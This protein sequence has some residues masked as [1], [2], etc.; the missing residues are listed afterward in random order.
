MV[1]TEEI[2]QAVVN[3]AP[4]VTRPKLGFSIDSIVGKNRAVQEESRDDGDSDAP[5]SRTPSP[6]NRPPHDH[7]TH[8]LHHRGIDSPGSADSDPE[9]R[10]AQPIPRRPLPL[11]Q[12]HLDM[13]DPLRAPFSVGFPTPQFL[14]R[15]PDQPQPQ[16]LYP[17]LLAARHSRFFAQRFPGP[18]VPSFLLHPFR[19]PKRIRTAF[20]PSQLLKLEH[21]FEKN[22]YVVGAERKQ[23]AQSLS[24]TETQVKVWFQNRRTK[25]KRQKQEESEGGS[26]GA[27]QSNNNN[28]N[29]TPPSP[30]SMSPDIELEESDEED[31]PMA[32]S[33]QQQ[34]LQLQQ[35]L[36]QLQGIPPQ[37]LNPQLQQHIQLL[38]QQHHHLLQQQALF[39]AAA[40][41]VA[42]V[43]FGHHRLS[44][45]AFS[46]GWMLVY[47]FVVCRYECL[48]F[49]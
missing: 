27:G 29:T 31:D 1:S 2:T 11:P 14:M 17:W 38:Q 41:A 4:Q 13:V 23:L 44:S 36:Q 9:S 18:D 42:L 15:S 45:V 10:G 25:H 46:A 22:H 30:G 26:V 40:A 37:L 7:H 34:H 20:S 19:K 39:A 12:T 8:P 32:S 49:D 21:A 33:P 48:L 43:I 28:N 6:S 24:L 16:P 5:A 3:S 35:Q 47:S